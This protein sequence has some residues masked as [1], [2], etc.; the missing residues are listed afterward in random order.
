MPTTTRSMPAFCRLVARGPR[1]A[2]RPFDVL[3]RSASTSSACTFTAAGAGPSPSTSALIHLD[4]D[5]WQIGKNYP[6][7]VGLIGDSKAGLGELADLLG[8]GHSGSL[9]AKERIRHF[10]HRADWPS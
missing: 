4:N 2:G 9:K 6:V 10:T 1:P 3:W 8:A 7:E 5:P